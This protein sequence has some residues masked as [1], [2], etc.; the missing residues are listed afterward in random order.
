MATNEIAY[1]TLKRTGVGTLASD[2]PMQI[3]T[4]SIPIELLGRADIPVDL[5]DLYSLGWDTP[6][7]QRSDYLTD[8]AS[9][10]T[11]QVYG[12]PY[13]ADGTVQ[14]RATKYL[15]VTP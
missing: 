14:L 11:Y 7:P 1:M 4:M 15:G 13:I 6:T 2:L 12:N 3:D 8:Q 9:G 5:Y 10:I